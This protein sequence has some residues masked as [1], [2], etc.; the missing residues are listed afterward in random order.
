[1]RKFLAVVGLLFLFVPVYRAWTA[2]N[3]FLPEEDARF[4]AIEGGTGS[5]GVPTSRRVDTTSPLAGGGSLAANRTLSITQSDSSTDGFLS[6]SDWMT[7]NSKVPGTRTI[8]ASGPITGGGDL[9]ANRSIGITQS[10]TTTDGY[11][12]ST[13]F[14]T[15][16]NKVPTTRQVLTTSPLSGGA[17]LSGDV[18]LAISK[19]TASVDGYLSATD[20]VTFNGKQAAISGNGCAPN[21]Y[22]VSISSA[23][24]VGCSAISTTAVSS[25]A[26]TI[27]GTDID[28]KQGNDQTNIFKKTISGNTT[29]TFSR[30]AD[31]RTIVV[32]V[33]NSGSFTVTWP[34]AGANKVFWSSGTAPTQTTGTATDVYTFIQGGSVIVGSAV[35]NFAIP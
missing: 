21:Q 26:S 10:S 23:G 7:F 33:R 11:L 15:F 20:F 16:N 24:A 6:S 3:P 30:N 31:G 18:T 22:A 1:M 4:L 19:A 13:D 35:Q 17:S 12:S 14:V 27:S 25:G 9:S 2:P 32:W 8:T 28:W 34:A 29:F 5:S